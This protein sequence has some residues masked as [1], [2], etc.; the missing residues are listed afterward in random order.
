ML[1]MF[2]SFQLF[3]LQYIE[4]DDSLPALD[5][6]QRIGKLKPQIPAVNKAS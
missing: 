3:E 4:V 1:L 5:N 6:R 2:L